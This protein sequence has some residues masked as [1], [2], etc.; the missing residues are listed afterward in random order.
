MRA[1]PR[2]GSVLL[3]GL[4]A[5]CASEPRGPHGWPLVVAE[6]F[7]SAESFDEFVFS[8]SHA[9]R[10]AS[11]GSNHFLEQFQASAYEPRFRSPLNLA[12]LATPRLGDFALEAKLKQTG[13]EYPHRDMCVVFAYR[14]AEHFHYAHLA[15][16]A[17]ENAHHV[18][19]VDGAPRTPVTSARTNGVAWGTERWLQLRVERTGASVRVWLGDAAEPQLVA[20]GTAPGEGWIGF[21]T[22]DDTGAVD[23]VR[24]W[25]PRTDAE[26]APGFGAR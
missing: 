10:R 2:T 5:A 25:A 1:G 17:D 3:A 11:E 18:Q 16:A 19:R 23:D 13:R 21:G 24:V 7:E 9:W 15:S 12:V 20:D 4:A 14:D 26:R 8:D 22:F 6:D